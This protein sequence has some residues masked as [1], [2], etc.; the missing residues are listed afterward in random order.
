MKWNKKQF[1]NQKTNA[2]DDAPTS[3]RMAFTADAFRVKYFHNT[4]IEIQKY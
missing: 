3:V 2:I 4:N 1:P